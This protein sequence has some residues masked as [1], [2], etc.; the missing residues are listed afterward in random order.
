M[1]MADD[2]DDGQPN[3]LIKT[4]P[5]PSKLNSTELWCCRCCCCS[6]CCCC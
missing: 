2:G 4:H 6:Y 3:T 1:A 5:E